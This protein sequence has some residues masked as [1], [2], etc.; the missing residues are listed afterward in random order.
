MSKRL[1]VFLDLDQTVICSEPTEEF[2]FKLNRTKMKKF[3]RHNMDSYY[4]VFERP[5]VQEF[6]DFLFSNFNV[7]VWTA[8]TKD[9]ALFIIDKVILQKPDRK[10]DWIFFQYHCKIS[11][12]IKD[13][14]KNLSM[15]WDIYGINGYDETNTFII[16]DYDHVYNIQKDNCI[17]LKPFEFHEEG[18]EKDTELNTIVKQ[19]LLKLNNK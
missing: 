14:T 13:G 4:I 17:L 16:D 8:A 11:E 10:L 15:M 1:N 2:D 3:A 6:L 12:K 19:K 9:Y 7:S 18:S 5:G